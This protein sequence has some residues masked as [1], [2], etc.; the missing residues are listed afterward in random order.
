MSVQ[1][2]LAPSQG[3]SG[4]PDKPN[5][6][7]SNQKPPSQTHSLFV[8]FLTVLKECAKSNIS[9]S[10]YLSC[11]FSA[12]S[13]SHTWLHRN[14]MWMNQDN[15]AFSKAKQIGLSLKSDWGKFAFD[16]LVSISRIIATVSILSTPNNSISINIL[17]ILYVL[18]RAMYIQQIS[19]KSMI[20]TINFCY[21]CG[22]LILFCK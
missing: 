15:W 10:C 8:W 22:M 11:V 5:M 14:T 17:M 1:L 6:S 20:S 18:S 16:E 2:P 21:I 9:L 19:K 12:V 13:T 3:S 7:S 4:L